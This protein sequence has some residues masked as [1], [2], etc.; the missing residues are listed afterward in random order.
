MPDKLLSLVIPVYNVER[1]LPKCL[2]SVFI[3]NNFPEFNQLIEVIAVNDGSTDNSPCILE[4]YAKKYPLIVINQLNDG[5]SMARNAGTKAASGKYVEFID[6]DDYL[7]P[8]K[9]QKLTAYLQKNQ[10]C[11]LLLFNYA[12]FVDGSKHFS[13]TK[14]TGFDF[15]NMD[16]QTAM[17]VLFKKEINCVAAWLKIVNRNLILEHN[18]F[19]KKLHAEDVEWNPRVFGLVKNVGWLNELVYA[20]RIRQGSLAHSEEAHK[21]FVAAC[22][23]I[24]ESWTEFLADNDFSQEYKITLYHIMTQLFWPL[25]HSCS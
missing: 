21:K 18:L 22:P 9:L 15:K 8:G 1:Y 14:Q 2:D 7:L 17:T 6:S 11:D 16:G 20:Y 25:K 5:L 3:D 13:K 19:F 12:I 24:L 23:D 4:D 10:S